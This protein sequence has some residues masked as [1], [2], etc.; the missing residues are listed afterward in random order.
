MA[1]KF[2]PTKW[3]FS[4]FIYDI[5]LKDCVWKIKVSERLRC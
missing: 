4:R 3:I 2:K 5:I 1:I